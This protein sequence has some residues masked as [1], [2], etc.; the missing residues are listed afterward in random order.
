[1]CIIIDFFFPTS[2]ESI[3]QYSFFFSSLHKENEIQGTFP[4]KPC[5]V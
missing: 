4:P 2:E 5:G 1:M 3:F